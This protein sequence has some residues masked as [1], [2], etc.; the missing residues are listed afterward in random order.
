M[1]A[2]GGVWREVIVRWQI[3]LDSVHFRE[4]ASESDGFGCVCVQLP[5]EQH[6]IIHEFDVH[7]RIRTTESAHLMSAGFLLRLAVGPKWQGV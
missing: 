2:G 3:R 4:V 1:S 6:K 5:F 7:L